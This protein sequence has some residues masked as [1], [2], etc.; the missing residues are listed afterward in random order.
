M[1]IF[2][3]MRHCGIVFPLIIILISGVFGLSQPAYSQAIDSDGDG[4]DDSTDNCPSTANT[5]QL[6]TDADG[7]GDV[8]DNASS[9]A[10]PNQED[11]DADGVGDVADNCQLIANT[12]QLDTDADGVGDVCDTDDDNDTILDGV[13]NCPNIS[14]LDQFDLDGDGRGNVCDSDDDND[15]ILDQF[16]NCPSTP[17][18]SQ[19]DLDG[20]GI[21]DVC[22][23]DKN[24]IDSSTPS[25]TTTDSTSDTTTDI[26]GTA[27]ETKIT[28]S[29]I[30]ESY[31]FGD[32]IRYEGFVD[33]EISLNSIDITISSPSEIMV[34][35]Q[36]TVRS[37]G[38]FNGN[39]LTDDYW[40][41]SG[42]YTITATASSYFG[43]AMFSFS[44]SIGE[45]SFSFGG[46]VDTENIVGIE[47]L[48][49]L[50]V[51]GSKNAGM[52]IGP[53]ALGTPLLEISS[54]RVCGA[55]LCDEPMSIQEKI[56]NYLLEKFETRILE[57]AKKKFGF[58]VIGPNFDPDN[59][60]TH[61]T[62]SLPERGTPEME[63]LKAALTQG[64]DIH[65]LHSEATS[66]SA[67]EIA[68][69]IKE[70]S[71]DLIINMYKAD[72]AAEIG[73]LLSAQSYLDEMKSIVKQ[74]KELQA[75]NPTN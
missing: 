59:I 21:G 3:I 31:I 30:D 7:V 43:Q 1:T 35:E 29:T 5:T 36:N 24:E 67:Q 73:N 9:V 17:N 15:T 19:T 40:F 2:R 28:V 52:H 51:G 69:K 32:F 23:F 68:D 66:L 38:T 53:K 34:T 14:N 41:D 39:I 8:C 72:R 49:T 46:I 20:N 63:A 13:D 42:E 47:E 48:S 54:D 37:D 55:S 45:L 11:V 6:D 26:T 10:N 64:I 70:L 18:Q 74:I 33:D 27:T 12:N 25:D 71:S 22:D 16:D 56:E 4:I 44:G 50:N 60:P 58:G 65:H 57:T 61:G 75:Q 62:E